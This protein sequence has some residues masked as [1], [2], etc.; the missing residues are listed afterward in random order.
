MLIEAKMQFATLIT[1]FLCEPENEVVKDPALYVLLQESLTQIH[2]KAL[3]EV[4]LLK[5]EAL[6]TKTQKL[7]IEY[8]RL[9]IGPYKIPCPPFASCYLGTKQLNN[10][11]TGWVRNFYAECG[12]T[13]HDSQE[14]LP[15]HI[16]V[17]TEFLQYLLG[18]HL[19]AHESGKEK[20]DANLKKYNEFLKS[21]YQKWVPGFSK[22][23]ASETTEAFYGQLFTIIGKTSLAL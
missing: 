16:A 12:L 11:V 13:Y 3:P 1:A 18:Q 9:F 5:N 7:L 10:E 2:G 4:D 21:H 14:T 20:S 8:A 23:V 19:I 22:A 6:N 17:E 15:D